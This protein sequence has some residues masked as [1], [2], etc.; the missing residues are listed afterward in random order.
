MFCLAYDAALRREEVCSLLISDFDFANRLVSVR[1]VIAKGKR[2]RV[3]P[4]SAASAA[5]LAAYLRHRRELSLKAGPTFLSESRRN[6]AQP[7]SIWTWS[8]IVRRLAI[9]AG[10]PRFSTHTLRHLCLTDLA[11]SGWDL[12]E[13]ASFAGHRSIETTK[14]YIN[15]SCRDLAAKLARGMDQ[16]HKWRMGCMQE[17]LS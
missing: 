4:Y 13:I 7:L 10:L 15:L 16:I 2:Q 1:A 3:V 9:A 17:S 14:E 8:K 11:R 5:L 6:T 12:H